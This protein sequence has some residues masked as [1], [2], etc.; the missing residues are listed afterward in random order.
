MGREKERIMGVA[1]HYGPRSTGGSSGNVKTTGTQ[2]ELRVDLTPEFIT[3]GLVTPAVIPKGAYI[4]AAELQVKEAFDLGV[5]AVVDVGTKGSEATNGVTLTEANLEA[6]GVVD[7]TSALAG[8]WVANTPFA[9]ATI[10]GVA[11][12]GAAVTDDSVGEAYLVVR[13]RDNV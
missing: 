8:T 6:V 4:H 11:L 10:V 7:V 3:S 13:W 1:N 12:S 9:D 5:G 2:N